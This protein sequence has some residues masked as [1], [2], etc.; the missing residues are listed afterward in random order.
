MKYNFISNENSSD[1][2]AIQSK[3][4]TKTKISINQANTV[5]LIILKSA[6]VPKMKIGEFFLSFPF[7]TAH[8]WYLLSAK[9]Q[10]KYARDI[11]NRYVQ[12]GA[13]IYLYKLHER[14]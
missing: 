4:K 6:S 10:K 5:C 12:M 3:T 8:T 14:Q 1:L 9:M 11:Q 13:V 2:L 7:E